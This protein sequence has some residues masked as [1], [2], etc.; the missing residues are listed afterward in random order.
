[1]PK[2]SVHVMQSGERVPMLQDELGLPL[3]YPT[4][5]ATSQLRNAGVAVNTIRNK[6]ADLMVLLRWEA[7]SRRDLVSSIRKCLVHVH[8]LD[9]KLGRSLDA[10][11][12]QMA[13]ILLVLAKD[14][15]LGRVDRVR[16]SNAVV[17]R[18][19]GHTPFV[20][21]GEANYQAHLLVAV[22]TG[23]AAQTSV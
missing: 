22:P 11:S 2:L 5:F 1:M 16:L 19:A 21:Q 18:S 3:F 7:A 12:E 14:N 9:T 23:Q 8:A 10:A 6:L 13:A 15:E 20:M 4:L 17:G